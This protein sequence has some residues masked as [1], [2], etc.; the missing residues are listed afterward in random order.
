LE[1]DSVKTV[2]SAVPKAGTTIK[3]PPVGCANTLN[4]VVAELISW[5]VLILKTRLA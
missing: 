3:V 2:S 1:A 5:L 4:L